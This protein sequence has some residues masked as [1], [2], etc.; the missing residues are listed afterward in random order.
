[1]AHLT[2]VLTAISHPSR[3]AILAQLAQGP[4]RFT[5]IAARF[6]TTLNATTKH[7]KLL[8]RAQLITRER[9]G[10]E[11]Q[12]ALNPAPLRA[13]VEWLHPY[14]QFWTERL[15]AFAEHFR[16]AADHPPAAPTTRPA[17]P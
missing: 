5:D 9:Q 13:V 3:R 6:E 16:A 14:E 10:R 15:D 12:I 17:R 7:L 1:M 8:E 2:D 4:A 11:V